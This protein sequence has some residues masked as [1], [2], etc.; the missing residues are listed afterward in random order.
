M[1][2]SIGKIGI[3]SIFPKLNKNPD[4][5]KLELACFSH[6]ILQ[7]QNFVILIKI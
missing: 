7:I 6:K 1:K 4:N 3:H 2:H 5:S